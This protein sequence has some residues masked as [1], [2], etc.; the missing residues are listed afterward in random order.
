[1]LDAALQRLAYIMLILMLL[2][3]LNVA[4]KARN[5]AAHG[6]GNA[7]TNALA[8]VGKLTLRL[9]ALALAVLAD[10]FLSQALCANKAA[11]SLFGS[12]D[13]LVPVACSA[14]G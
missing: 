12:A 3:L 4:R 13:G 8:Q 2:L 11:D 6:A 5:G 9:L 7:I 1:M 10:A 14:V